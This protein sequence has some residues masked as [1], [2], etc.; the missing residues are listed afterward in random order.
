VLRGGQ[1]HQRRDAVRQEEAGTKVV[2]RLSIML[3]MGIVYVH[4]DA[5]DQRSNQTGDYLIQKYTQT[6]GRNKNRKEAVGPHGPYASDIQHLFK[7]AIKHTQVVSEYVGV[8]KE[9]CM[10]AVHNCTVLQYVPCSCIVYSM[11]THCTHYAHN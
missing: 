5:V 3:A 9:W 10:E 1:A 7:L 4:Q 11:F 6:I 2:K 8:S